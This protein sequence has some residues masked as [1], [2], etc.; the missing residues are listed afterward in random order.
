MTTNDEEYIREMYETSLQ[1]TKAQLQADRAEQEQALAEQ[2]EQNRKQTEEALRQTYVEAARQQK[3]NAEIQSAQG[4]NSGAMAQERLSRE[5]QTA[6]DLTAIRTAQME[7]DAQ[8]ERQRTLLGQQYAA[9]ITQAQK[10]NDLA[11]AEALYAAAQQEEA[12]LLEKKQAA[13]ALMAEEVGDFSL[14]KDLYGLTDEQIATLNGTTMPTPE[15]ELDE[16]TTTQTE[17]PVS[18]TPTYGGG[19]TLASIN[20]LGYDDLTP[21]KLVDLV[22]AGVVEEY[23]EDGVRKFRRIR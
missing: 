8:I 21:Q 9:A 19:T 17:Q 23:T 10:E 16:E 4:L 3:S 6:A 1:G 18:S 13:A 7:A 22:A 5:N 2:K 15:P 14:Y 11:K 12:L 20:T